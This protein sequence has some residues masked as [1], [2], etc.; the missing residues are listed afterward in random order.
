VKVAI[1]LLV[2]I[3]GLFVYAG[4]RS[5]PAWDADRYLGEGSLM[6]RAADEVTPPI[7]VD[8]LVGVCLDRTHRVFAGGPFGTPPCV[9]TVACSK[10]PFRFLKLRIESSTAKIRFE[11]GSR[12]PSGDNAA[13]ACADDG[14][15]SVQSRDLKPSRLETTVVI[16][17]GGGTLTIL[18]LDLAAGCR[19]RLL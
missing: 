15:L 5:P 3:A 12:E 19:V 8:A 17:R 1:A 14:G 2:V 18:C 11:P 9:A 10:A 16:P 4:V 13:G 7:D 6:Q